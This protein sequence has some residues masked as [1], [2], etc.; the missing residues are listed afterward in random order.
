MSVSAGDFLLYLILRIQLLFVDYCK[1][2][3]QIFVVFGE[4]DVVFDFN[5][6]KTIALSL[7]RNELKFA[8]GLIHK[9]VQF[10][11][12]LAFWTAGGSKKRI[13]YSRVS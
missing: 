2:I 13:Q 3:Y 11:K 4:F 12:L 10:S 7:C 9:D 8:L 5:D 6:K 1:F